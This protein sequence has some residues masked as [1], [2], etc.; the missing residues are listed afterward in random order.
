MKESD[1]DRRSREKEA[2]RQALKAAMQVL[3]AKKTAL[4]KEQNDLANEINRYNGLA[5]ADVSKLLDEIAQREEAVQTLRAALRRMQTA[6][7]VK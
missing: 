3:D 7:G 4:V 6:T 2:K 1:A 5:E